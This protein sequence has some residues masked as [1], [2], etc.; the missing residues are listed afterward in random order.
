MLQVNGQGNNFKHRIEEFFSLTE[1]QFRNLIV[2]PDT[3]PW[4]DFQFSSESFHYCAE[5]P[6]MQNEVGQLTKSS[7][8]IHHETGQHDECE[9]TKWKK[10]T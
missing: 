4:I 7:L 2:N 8:E 6:N 10:F 1:V 5:N 9:F 3:V